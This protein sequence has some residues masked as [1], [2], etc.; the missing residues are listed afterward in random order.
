MQKP[1][2]LPLAATLCLAAVPALAQSPSFAQGDRQEL[3]S[4]S[5]LDWITITGEVSSAVGESF[6]LDYGR[7]NITVEMDDF[8][9]YEENVL[10]PG[11]DVTVTGMVDDDFYEFRTIEASAVYIDKLRAYR[12]AS[13]AD[14]EGGY[15]AH[16]VAENATE[17]EWIGLSGTVV[18]RDGEELRVDTG[19]ERIVVSLED[20]ANPPQLDAGDRVSI[21]GAMDDA[22]LFEKRELEAQSV[23]VLER[24]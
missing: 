3:R 4:T 20:L 17:E 12:Y 18:G 24:G 15:Y 1:L 14:E 7:G 6:L 19:P 2:R 21:Y 10:L 16:P 9:W 8:D 22:D 23:T 11:D 5:N 13:S